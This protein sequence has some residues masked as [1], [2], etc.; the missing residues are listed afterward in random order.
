M[1]GEMGE[2]EMLSIEEYT[3][4]IE[5]GRQGLSHSGRAVG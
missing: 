2:S 4:C 3:L 5:Y 1:K